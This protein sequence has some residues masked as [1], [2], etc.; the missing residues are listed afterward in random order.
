M[1]RSLAIML[2]TSGAL[3]LIFVPKIKAIRDGVDMETALYG[4]S[5]GQSPSVIT[6]KVMSREL[7][8]SRAG[9]TA[10]TGGNDSQ[11]TKTSQT[12][13]SPTNKKSSVIS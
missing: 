4:T 5:Q 8:N 7:T 1:I 2:G 9:K 13:R 6:T 10:S 3:M 12:S 11:I